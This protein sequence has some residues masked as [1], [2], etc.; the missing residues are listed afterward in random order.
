[1]TRGERSREKKEPGDGKCTGRRDPSEKNPTAYMAPSSTV[2]L[3]TPVCLNTKR[4][5]ARLLA[6]KVPRKRMERL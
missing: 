6:G 5:G 3:P 4:K 2:Y 1:M